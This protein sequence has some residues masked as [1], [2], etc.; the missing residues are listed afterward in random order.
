MDRP[1][2]PLTRLIL[3]TSAV[4]QAVFALADLFAPSLVNTLFWP[5]PFEPLPSLWLRFEAAVYLAMGL[6]AIYAL[7]QNSWIAARTFLAIGG[8]YVAM[9][10]IMS[11]LAIVTPPGAPLIMWVYL[12]LAL[13]YLPLVATAWVRQS[14][15]ASL[16]VNAR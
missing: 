15:Q 6:G 9:C 8:S 1:L 4:V 14:G 7:Y 13:I 16:S 12:A 3:I 2:L 11:I 10:V 5:A